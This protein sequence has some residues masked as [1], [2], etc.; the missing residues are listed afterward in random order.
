MK[1]Q[2][3]QEPKKTAMSKFQPRRPATSKRTFGK[4]RGK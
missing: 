3:K 1:K 4:P 2:D